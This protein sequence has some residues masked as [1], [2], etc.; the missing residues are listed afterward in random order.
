MTCLHDECEDK[1]EAARKDFVKKSNLARA[2]LTEREEEAAALAGR[3]AE[4]Q[5][6]IAS[7]APSERKIFQFAE[8]QSQRDI[9]QGLHRQVKEKCFDFFL[10]LFFFKLF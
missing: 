1:L 5:A 8:L 7:G 4:L 6:E 10:L 3:V 9:A 2:L